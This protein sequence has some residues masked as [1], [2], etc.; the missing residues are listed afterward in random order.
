MV[1]G[2]AFLMNRATPPPL[3]VCVLSALTNVKPSK[4][5]SLLSIDGVSHVSV[6]AIM[7]G[8]VESICT[9][10]SGSL[11]SKLRALV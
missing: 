7:S 3:R 4:S 1:N 11:L 10:S 9:P 6:T 5:S 2:I 8:L